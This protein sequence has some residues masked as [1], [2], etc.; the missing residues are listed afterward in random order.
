MFKFSMMMQK[1]LWRQKLSLTAYVIFFFPATQELKVFALDL[2]QS[3][4]V[5][6]AVI[7]IKQKAGLLF[8]TGNDSCYPTFS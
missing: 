4:D 6:L 1:F 7:L 3:G 8:N 2:F 5:S